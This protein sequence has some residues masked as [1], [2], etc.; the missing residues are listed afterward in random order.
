MVKKIAGWLLVIIAVFFFV[1]AVMAPGPSAS[2]DRAYHWPIDPPVQITSTLGEYR[3]EHFHNGIDFSTRG[4]TGRWVR[5][6]E[7]GQVVEVFYDPEAY[8]ITV[9]LEHEDGWRSWYSHLERIAASILEK[10]NTPLYEHVRIIPAEEIW[11]SRGRRIGVA[12]ETGRGPVHLHFA[13]QKRSGE[14]VNP[15]GLFEEPLPFNPNP[16][17]D[18]LHV[19]PLD[20]ESWVNGTAKP[21]VL[22]SRENQPLEL[23]G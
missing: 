4:R 16:Y 10:L 2:D 3:G 21:V 22:D 19:Y 5:A 18:E 20:G 7:R 9:V 6:I 11:V 12:G 8:G 23:W 1:P 17:L 15:I 13:L 14:F